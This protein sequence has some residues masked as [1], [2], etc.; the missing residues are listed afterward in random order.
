MATQTREH[1][2]HGGHSHHHH[3]HHG[4]VYL[5]SAN[6]SDA[7]VRITRIGLVAN[8]AMA[9]GKFIGGYVFHSQA[10]IADAYHALTDLVS[11]FLTLGTVAWS[12]KP[13][14]E[15]FPN[16]YG[17]IESIGA[18][19]VSGLLLCGGVFMGL[20][21]GQVLLDQFFPEAAEAI[22]HSGVLGHGH[23]HAHGVQALGPNINAAWLAGGSIIVKEWLYRAT[24]KIANERKSSVLASNAVHHR[25]DSLTSIVALFT[26]GG[27]YMFQD[28]S[29]LDPVGGLLIS[30]M[31]IKAGWANTTTSLLELADT[32]VDDDIKDSVRNAAS[33]IL[34]KLE[35]PHAIQIRDVQG[36]KSGQNYLMEIELAVPGA[37]SLSRSRE[38]EETVRHAVGA[39]VRGVKRLKVR[40]VPSELEHLDFTEEFIAPEVIRQ[41][42]PEPQE[43][44]ID[45]VHEAHAHDHQHKGNENRKTR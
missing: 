35:D 9:I 21:S 38:I 34:A 45:A 43:G 18:L 36:M 4:N 14:T 7:G 42:S 25:I 3:H 39:G 20:N 13:P 26:I 17:K 23:S 5:T 6:K 16:G 22:A 44:D 24:M 28:A 15:R 10:L 40:F 1:G 33:K 12:L 31:V 19:G 41:S 37:W 29:W 8:L 2:G 30:L 32:T 11:D 27:S